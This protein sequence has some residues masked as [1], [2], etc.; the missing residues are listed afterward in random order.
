MRRARQEV[1]ANKPTA[2]TMKQLLEFTE[3]AGTWA[4][5][6]LDAGTSERATRALEASAALLFA[7]VSEAVSAVVAGDEERRRVLSLV[8]TGLRDRGV[9]AAIE[10]SNS[11]TTTRR[12]S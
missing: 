12:T 9:V 1:D 7:V 5:T 8:A 2:K 11:T 6:T 10:A 4:K 3:R